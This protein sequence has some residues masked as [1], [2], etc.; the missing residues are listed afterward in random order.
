MRKP[1]KLFLLV[2]FLAGTLFAG[3]ARAD[4]R[5]NCSQNS[6]CTL[7]PSG[8]LPWAN[9][10]LTW[11]FKPLNPRVS[12]YIFIRNQNTTSAHSSQT[13]TV[14]QT[15]F[16]QDA[17]PD[18]NTNS[19]K[20]TQDTLTQNSTAGA[21]CNSVNAANDASPGASGLGSCYVNTMFAAQVAVRITGANTQAGSPD[22][23]DLAIVQ[24]TGIPGGQAPGS[25]S[26]VTLNAGNNPVSQNYV[27]AVVGDGQADTNIPNAFPTSNPLDYLVFPYAYNGTNWDRVRGTANT[28]LSDAPP[29]MVV[30]DGLSQAFTAG[31]GQVTNPGAAQSLLFVQ[32]NSGAKALYFNTLTI[33]SSVAAQFS[34][35][36]TSTAGTTCTAANVANQKIGNATA[37]VA[38]AS[39]SCTGGPTG[40]NPQMF[41]FVPAGGTV[42]IDL[43]GFIAPS[44]ST[45]GIIAVN[46][47]S[48]TGLVS[49]EVSWHEK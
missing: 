27:S 10:N 22:N 13:I 3:I 24:E 48:I 31:S 47:A 15:P 37:S 11:I 45:T 44:G 12:V 39:T 17:S 9:G 49:V 32:D 7:T 40:I 38:A 1:A 20:W 41:Y 6:T 29:I 14:F 4:V 23:F 21:S 18:L 34:V 30:S 42:T 5:V 36:Q 43:R 35:Q 19:S 16:S 8:G 33:S 28:G 46:S 2:F 25:T 26:S